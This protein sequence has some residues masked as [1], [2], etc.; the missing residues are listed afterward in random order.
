MDALSC[1]EKLSFRLL[2]ITVVV[3]QHIVFQHS[4]S[5]LSLSYFLVPP[6]L[7]PARA[8]TLHFNYDAQFNTAST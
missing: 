2:L 1:L 7:D 6:F 4:G 5:G 3:F 8:T